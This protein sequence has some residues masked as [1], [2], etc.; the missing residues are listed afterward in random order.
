MNVSCLVNN[1]GQRNPSWAQSLQ[2]SWGLP[3]HRAGK[4]IKERFAKGEHHKAKMVSMYVTFLCMKLVF[5]ENILLCKI[6]E[7]HVILKVTFYEI[8][9]VDV[10]HKLMCLQCAC[11]VPWLFSLKLTKTHVI[12][13]ANLN[14]V[15]KD[16]MENDQ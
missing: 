9:M 8:H 1:K 3:V 10:G 4:P 12:G 16:Q 5:Y 15:P 14:L 11:D 2:E 6:D 13:G 7:V